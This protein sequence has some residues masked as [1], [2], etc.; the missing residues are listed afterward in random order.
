MSYAKDQLVSISSRSL[1]CQLG[2]TL[3]PIT[4]L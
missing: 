3:A 4:T 2:L 1:G